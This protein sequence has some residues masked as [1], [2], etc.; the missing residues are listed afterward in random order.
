MISWLDDRVMSGR[1]EYYKDINTVEDLPL[2]PSIFSAFKSILFQ[3][4]TTLLWIPLSLVCVPLY[5]PGLIVWGRPPTIPPWSRFYRY[6]TATWRDG[7]PED[8][9]PFTNR[10]LVFQTILDAVI[11]SPIKG[12]CWFLDELL[13]PSYHKTDIKDPVFILSANRSGSTQLTDYLEDQDKENFLHPLMIEAFFPYIWV[14]RL[15]MVLPSLKMLRI[16]EHIEAKFLSAFGEEFKKRHN[17]SLCKPETWDVMLGIGHFFTFVCQYLGCSF[18]KWGFVFCALKSHPVD[19]EFCKC[20]VEL[21]DCILKKV[22]YH[23]GSPKQ[24]MVVKGHFLFAAKILENSYHGAKFITI[25]R[26][27]VAQYQSLVNWTKVLS[28]DCPPHKILGLFPSTWRVVRD[29]SLEMQISYCEEEMLFYNQ[30][31]ENRRNKLAI[32]FTSYVNNLTGTLQN[33]YSFL[34]IPLPVEM[35]SKASALQSSTHNRT[36][37]KNTYDPKY[38]R[39]LS[40]L[41]VDEDKLREHLSDYIDWMKELDKKN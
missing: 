22:M 14:W 11:K 39:S 23:R 29:Y 28:F 37:R 13:Y 1:K 16:S 8:S 25:V 30:S 4:I 7:K 32:S 2:R 27:P 9:I 36:K 26:D 5:L 20:F 41:G 18:Y 21:S 35:L 17:L 19:R 40:S 3:C 24:R 15:Y 10:I 6:L 33:I 34:N 38:N 12:V 31:E